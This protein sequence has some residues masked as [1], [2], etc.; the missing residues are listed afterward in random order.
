MTKDTKALRYLLL[1]HMW[2]LN[3]YVGSGTY[4]EIVCSLRVEEELRCYK[5]T[6]MKES[7]SYG[8]SFQK[9]AFT[10]YARNRSSSARDLVGNK[11]TPQDM[12][13]RQ[14]ALEALGIGNLEWP[15][16]TRPF[17]RRWMTFLLVYVSAGALTW[18]ATGELG[19]PLILTLSFTI[20]LWRP[21]GAYLVSPLALG[22]AFVGYPYTAISASVIHLVFHL[23]EPTGTVRSL[24]ALTAFF[25]AGYAIA[26]V[27]QRV[28]Y[29]LIGTECLVILVVALA[30]LLIRWMYDFHFR[31]TPL[32]L[33]FLAIGA[34]MDGH[35]STA[36]G[37]L[38]LSLVDTIVSR[39]GIGG[40]GGQKAASG[41]NG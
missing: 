26:H 35:V 34:C 19:F 5:V 39:K 13:A 40:F 8:K 38:V 41:L 30:L 1:R 15:E 22:F 29:P 23:L 17:F 14:F 2:F 20:E 27:W 3:R 32:A 25:V 11:S 24:R 10:F 31:I 7:K 33:P 28:Q 6:W 12:L 36:T 21:I 16:E 9:S 18:F 4:E 37:V